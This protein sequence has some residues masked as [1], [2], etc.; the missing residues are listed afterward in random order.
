MRTGTRPRL[1]C[2]SLHRLIAE[3]LG[4]KVETPEEATVVFADDYKPAEGQTVVR[5]F[6]IEKLVSLVN[7]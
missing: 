3:Y 4:E 5:S 7:K 1:N 6:D 2:R